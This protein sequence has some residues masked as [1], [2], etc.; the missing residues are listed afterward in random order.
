MTEHDEPNHGSFQGLGDL[1]SKEVNVA[2][3]TGPLLSRRIQIANGP[4][5]ASPF[6]RTTGGVVIWVENLDLLCQVTASHEVDQGL[7]T[8]PRPSD[9]DDCYFDDMTDGEEEDDNDGSQSEP[10]KEEEKIRNDGLGAEKLREHTRSR[11][12]LIRTRSE[13]QG[14]A[15]PGLS[16]EPHQ[17]STSSPTPH[18]ELGFE[19]SSPAIEAGTNGLTLA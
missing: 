13:E 12:N 19:Q 17:P 5:A 15:A 8:T 9:V 6:G 14:G 18:S 10:G 16:H 4:R 1:A 3:P 2:D 7:A 11:P